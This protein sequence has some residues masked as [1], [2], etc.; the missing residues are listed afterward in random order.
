M[1]LTV[2]AGCSFSGVAKRSR[3]GRKFDLMSARPVSKEMSL[4]ISRRR[5]LSS[6]LLT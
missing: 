2:A 6:V 5:R 1:M 3:M 4:G